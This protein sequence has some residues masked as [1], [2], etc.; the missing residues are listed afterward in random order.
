MAKKKLRESDDT[1]AGQRTERDQRQKHQSDNQQA[2]RKRADFIFKTVEP[3]YFFEK[4]D[5]KKLAAGIK[6]HIR[7]V[8]F[9]AF[10]FGLM[11]ASFTYRSLTNYK[12]EA[13]LIF[14]K[15]GSRTIGD[16]GFTLTSISLPTALDIIRLPAH[17]Q[18]VKS[19]LGLELSPAALQGMTDVPT[20][21]NDSN[22]IRIVAS[23]DNPNL[24]I[25]IANT[26]ARLAAKSSQEFTQ[27]QLLQGLD[28]YTS[29]LE[30][31][32]Q[33][34]SFENQQIENFKK[35]NRY[36]EM[37]A[38]YS[39]LLDEVS[40]ARS[41]LEDASLDYNSLLV[42]YE[43][44][45]RQAAGLPEQIAISI[46]SKG[47]PMQTRILSLQ[48][49]LAEARS[50]YADT[51]PKV[52]KLE[53]E[54]QMLLGQGIKGGEKLYERNTLKDS[55]QVELMR[56][57]GQ[58]RAAQKKKQD[59][60]NRVR[61]LENQLETVPEEQMTLAR[62]LQQKDITESRIKNLN[63]AI[64]Q[65]KMMINVPKGSL[66]LYQMADQAKPL[67]E[68]TTIKILPLIGLIFGFG[69][70]VVSAVGFEMRDPRICTAKQVDIHYTLPALTQIPFIDQ[71]TAE[72][73]RDE[74]LFYVRD[75]TEHL[76]LVTPD[77]RPELPS[78]KEAAVLTLLSSIDGEGKSTFA[79]QLAD[80]YAR[81]NKK[82]MLLKF[83]YRKQ[84]DKDEFPKGFI[85][86][87]NFLKGEG[88]EAKTIIK[89][90][91]DS[92]QV[93]EFEPMMKELIKGEVM[94]TL[95]NKLKKNYDVILIDPPGILED[96]YAINLAS[97]ADCCL[98][99]VNA[100]LIPKKL[101][102][103]SLELLGEFGVVPYGIIL[104]KIPHLYIYDER[105]RLEMWRTKS[106]FEKLLFWK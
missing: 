40:L 88:K 48:A 101:I 1:L 65:T 83:D 39:G 5:T 38:T 7:F 75:L 26:L 34:L 41:K 67:R 25:D 70:G 28:S 10:A 44:L 94:R 17:Y 43:N 86:L 91:Y 33:R 45:R 8:L 46:E 37:D 103:Q 71:L 73:E 16:D 27:K 29:Q 104:N 78:Q 57:Q 82:V 58:V 56:M 66:E 68:S 18:A 21:R 24:A 74:L 96:D 4:Y 2:R 93:Q 87:E 95:W 60:A 22:L 98:F 106:G 19:I 59:I 32:Q 42:E 62:L 79:R 52:K 105:V 51:N 15:E 3:E 6:R 35:A 92:M 49:A 47:S 97:L 63:A 64:E 89:G 13:V 84:N 9:S 14:Q 76:G 102:D 81:F 12:A 90:A 61:L 99:L 80:Y 36:F 72:N 69:L 85:P 55:L 23:A 31:A 100:G 30:E 11:A 54:L 53:D 77:F 20:P 50:K